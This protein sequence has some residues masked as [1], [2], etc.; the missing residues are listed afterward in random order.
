MPKDDKNKPQT[1]TASPLATEQP[2]PATPALVMASEFSDDEFYD[3]GGLTP[4]YSS[5]E[6]YEN[7]FPEVVGFPYDIEELPTI[8][9]TT[10]DGKQTF[11]TPRMVR[12]H[13]ARATKATTGKRGA[14]Q[15]IDRLPGEDILVPMTGS[16]QHNKPLLAAVNHPTDL[17]LAKMEIVGQIPLELGDMWDW[18]VQLNKKRI[19]REGRFNVRSNEGMVPLAAP[20]GNGAP[21]LPAGQLVN[22]QTGEV[23]DAV[24]AGRA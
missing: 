20:A 19:K 6:A 11:F 17:F 7:K 14:R 15:I 22:P 9:R 1:T 2:K 18:R 23:R 10:P 24:P 3:V 5:K 21:A 12:V 13:L 4:I 16:L 8:V